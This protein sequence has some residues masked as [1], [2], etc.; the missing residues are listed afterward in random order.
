MLRKSTILLSKLLFSFLIS[1]ASSFEEGIKWKEKGNYVE[2][3]KHF[4]KAKEANPTDARIAKEYAN[5][6]YQLR[7]YVKALPVYEEIIKKEPKN[8]KVLIRLAKCIALVPKNSKG[9]NMQSAL[10]N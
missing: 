3:L 5:A 10:L 4:E 7:K 9:Q 2:A 6:A 1:T 8:I